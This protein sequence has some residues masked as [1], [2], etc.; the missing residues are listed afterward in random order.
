M[1]ALDFVFDLGED[2]P[3]L[4][5]VGA[6]NW[7]VAFQKLAVLE[8]DDDVSEAVVGVVG[9]AVGVLGERAGGFVVE[10]HGVILWL[11]D[12]RESFWTFTFLDKAKMPDGIFIAAVVPRF[13]NQSHNV[14]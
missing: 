11:F 5:G 6:A 1:E 14:T 10:G 7:E 3:I 12:N 13:D 2:G 9:E 8:G 4:A